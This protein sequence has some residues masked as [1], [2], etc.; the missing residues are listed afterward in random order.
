MQ[1]YKHIFPVLQIIG[2][3]FPI[4]RVCEQNKIFLVWRTKE[5]V[6]HSTN[7]SGIH[8]TTV[9]LHNSRQIASA[10]QLMILARRAVLRF[11]ESSGNIS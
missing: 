2:F 9:M 11:S 3:K 5:K 1:F 10:D 6:V 8:R 4:A 7:I